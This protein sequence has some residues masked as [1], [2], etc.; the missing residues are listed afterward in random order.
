M[1]FS[2]RSYVIL[3]PDECFSGI[4][5]E[6]NVPEDTLVVINVV[7]NGPSERVGLK[8]GDRIVT[9]DGKNVAGV[10]FPQDSMIKMLRGPINTKVNVGIKLK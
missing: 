4:G 5:V 3:V 8:G 7:P 2:D 10:K 9:I 6:F 1:R